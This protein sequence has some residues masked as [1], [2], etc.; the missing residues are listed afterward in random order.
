[1]TRTTPLTPE[2][3]ARMAQLCRIIETL[4]LPSAWYLQEQLLDMRSIAAEL[5]RMFNLPEDPW[6][7]PN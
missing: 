1:M 7:S 2:E 3:L 5:R 4:F 6:N